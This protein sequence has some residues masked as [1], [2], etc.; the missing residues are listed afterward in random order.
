VGTKRHN[1]DEVDVEYAPEVQED[2]CSLEGVFDNDTK[3]AI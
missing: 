1:R 3:R 2:E